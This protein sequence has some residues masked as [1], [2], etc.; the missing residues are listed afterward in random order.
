MKARFVDR[1]AGGVANE[2]KVGYTSL[3]QF[4]QT[5]IKKDV[6]LLKNDDRVESVAWHFFESPVT[7]RVGPS[8][9]LR[10]ALTVAGIKIVCP[11]CP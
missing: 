9:P 4:V 8:G 7:G 1:F 3:T 6:W 11:A 2:S 10:E 5:Q